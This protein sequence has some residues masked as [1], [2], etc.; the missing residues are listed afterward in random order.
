ME[1]L[2]QLND[3]RLLTWSRDG[4]MQLWDAKGLPGEAYEQSDHIVET[5]MLRDERVISRAE[6]GTIRI[7]RVGDKTSFILGIEAKPFLGITELADGYLL[8]WS[9]IIN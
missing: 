9:K 5:K 3:G 8:T 7:W 2:F 6:S 4:V 1:G